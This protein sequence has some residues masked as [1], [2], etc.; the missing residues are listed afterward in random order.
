MPKSL[1]VGWDSRVDPESGLR[2]SRV[3]GV[4]LAGLGLRRAE[5]EGYYNGFCNQA[6]WPLL[7]C[8][9]RRAAFDPGQLEAYLAVQERFADA[10]APRIRSGD[11][12]WVHDYH[13]L[14]LGEALRRRGVQARLGF[15]LHTPFPPDDIWAVLPRSR[16]F[17]DSLLS[18]DL[19][20]FH[21]LRYVENYVQACRRELGA[22]W[23][24]ERLAFGSHL[25]KVGVFPVGIEPSDFEPRKSILRRRVRSRALMRLAAGRRILL[26]VDRLDYTKGLV[27]RFHAFE[28]LLRE[29]KRWR[30]RV[31]LV[32]IASPS[33]SALPWYRR[34]RQEIEGLVG[35]INGEL[36]SA[37]SAPIHYLHRSY[38]RETLARFYREA[39]VALVTPLRD[40]MNLVAKEYVAAQRPDDPGVLVLSRFAGAA[41][42]MTDALQVN[43]YV[44]TE[45]AETIGQAL[46]MGLSERRE[47]HRR[48]LESVREETASRWAERFVDELKG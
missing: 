47:R 32:Q 5:V 44:P 29:S 26:G 46:E 34:E 8:F 28:L 40:G 17:L 22:E 31:C 42:R 6:L 12:V 35:R 27:E 16:R 23:D 24:G 18:F 21:T 38:P 48:L 2:E 33:R 15:F 37:D 20:G 13:L 39:D 14:R 11:A 1:W 4:T 10:L 30:D 41:E 19:I 9:P 45:F 36:G 7:H 3:Q 43:P 25:Q